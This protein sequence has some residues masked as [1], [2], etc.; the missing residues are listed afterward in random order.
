MTAKDFIVDPDTLDFTKV[1]A[2]IDE[3]R[4]YNPQRFEMEQLT[5]IVHEDPEKIIC[6]GYK[7][8]TDQEFWVS[9]HMPGMPLMPGVVMLEAVAQV[10]CYCCHKYKLLGD[11][12]VGFGGLDEVKFPSPVVP[13]DRLV[14]MCQ[15]LKLRKPRL[16]ICRFQG[17]VNRTIVV[18]GI[19]KGI[20]IPVD[21]LKSLGTNPS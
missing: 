21:Y 2:D 6:V 10:C 16:I 18:E 17:M 12:M 3:I 13:G 15:Q 14:V 1:V 5:A 8:I 7:D 4:K 9:G 19:L 11:S 20:P